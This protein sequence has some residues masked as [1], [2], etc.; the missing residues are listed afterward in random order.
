MTDL[1]EQAAAQRLGDSSKILRQGH[2]LEGASVNALRRE[3]V[4]FY[5]TVRS[6]CKVNHAQP[7]P[8]LLL[9]LKG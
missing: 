5:N 4:L 8:D 1:R 3:E 7:I 2:F 6:S 9:L